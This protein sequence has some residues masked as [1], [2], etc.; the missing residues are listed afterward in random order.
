MRNKYISF[1]SKYYFY[2]LKLGPYSGKLLNEFSK[3]LIASTHLIYLNNTF[4]S[5]VRWNSPVLKCQDDPFIPCG[6]C[7]DVWSIQD[8]RWGI[9]VNDMC[10]LVC[11]PAAQYPSLSCWFNQV[12]ILKRDQA[13]LLDSLEAPEQNSGFPHSWNFLAKVLLIDYLSWFC[14]CVLTGADLRPE[15]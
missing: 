14:F 7:W 15:S 2:I 3:Q 9:F 12:W 4:F 5:L 11:R 13:S 6:C 1:S 10:I 8:L